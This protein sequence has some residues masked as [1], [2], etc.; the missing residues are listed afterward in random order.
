MADDKNFR[1]LAWNFLNDSM[2]LDLC[3]YKPP[4]VLAGASILFA[5]EQIHR[6]APHEWFESMGFDLQLLQSIV[7]S[8]TELYK[9]PRVTWLKPHVEVEY[10]MSLEL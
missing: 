3:V 1:Q 7:N 2:R 10:L 4:E 9:R 6:T 5:Y 8:V